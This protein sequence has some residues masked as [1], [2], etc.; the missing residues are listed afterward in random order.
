MRIKGI[1]PQLGTTL[2]RLSI[3]EWSRAVRRP[4]THTWVAKQI[5]WCGAKL[6][7]WISCLARAWSWIDWSAPWP[8]PGTDF[9]NLSQNA[10]VHGV[11]RLAL[12]VIDTRGGIGK[13]RHMSNMFTFGLGTT[14]T[15]W[16]L[17]GAKQIR[18]YAVMVTRWLPRVRPC[19]FSC[20]PTCQTAT[21]SHRRMVPIA[22]SSST[23]AYLWPH[24]LTLRLTWPRRHCAPPTKSIS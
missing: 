16:L 18:V 11:T 23:S 22:S 7:S 8:Q 21:G 20:Q 2:L 3:L 15:C 14:F 10:R 12:L 4:V 17:A 24:L 13:F 5:D 6:L 19:Q 9:R 1:H